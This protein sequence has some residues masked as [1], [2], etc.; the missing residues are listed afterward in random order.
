MLHLDRY[1]LRHRQL[2]GEHGADIGSG[3]C[4]VDAGQFGQFGR[5]DGRKDTLYAMFRAASVAPDSRALDAC[6]R[7]IDDHRLHVE[8][9]CGAALALAYAGA[10]ALK[11]FNR[12][13]VVACGVTT[14]TLEQLQTWHAAALNGQA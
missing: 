12:V 9:A 11:G 2:T 6:L 5:P 14:N 3:L 1:R 8:P 13:L 10:P 4:R 7:F